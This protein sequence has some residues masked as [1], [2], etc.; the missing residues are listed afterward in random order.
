MTESWPL[1]HFNCGLFI[2]YFT[3]INM[4]NEKTFFS[5]T[6]STNFAT[7]PIFACNNILVCVPIVTTK[8]PFTSVALELYEYVYLCNDATL[9]KARTGAI[10]VPATGSGSL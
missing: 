8:R 6:N 5:G 2:F 3:S 1:Q 10:F 9:V 4:I 7:I